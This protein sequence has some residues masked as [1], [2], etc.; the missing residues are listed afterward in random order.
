MS[1]V[2][3]A[4][5]IETGEEAALGL[6]KFTAEKENKNVDGGSARAYY[7][8]LLVERARAVYHSER[9]PDE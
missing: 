8:D 7:P 9:L 3:Q 6:M 5:R 1:Q 4:G 2:T